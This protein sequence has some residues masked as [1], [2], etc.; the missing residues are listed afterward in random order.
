MQINM[1]KNYFE[2]AVA[3]F[4][5]TYLAACAPFH[6]NPRISSPPL[7]PSDLEVSCKMQGEELANFVKRN[8]NRGFV[9][10]EARNNANAYCVADEVAQR[11]KLKEGY[12]L[13][14]MGNVSQNPIYMMKW[15][16]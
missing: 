16:K 7:A 1:A 2:S 10:F 6:N 8:E 12:D 14:E 9:Q 15:G 4:L 13:V 5:S 11:L 3:L